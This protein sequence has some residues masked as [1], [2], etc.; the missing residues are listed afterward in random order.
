MG[1]WCLQ[2]LSHLVLPSMQGQPSRTERHAERRTDLSMVLQLPSHQQS[3]AQVSLRAFWGSLK[4]LATLLHGIAQP[5]GYRAREGLVS[6]QPQQLQGRQ[7]SCSLTAA[8]QHPL[9]L[10]VLQRNKERGVQGHW[11]VR[12]RSG[13][14]AAAVN[15]P[16]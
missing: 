1:F 5:A 15:S 8:A 16:C 4:L 11:R 12:A 3:P 14:A 7:T 9:R 13:N 10:E 2:Q 6:C